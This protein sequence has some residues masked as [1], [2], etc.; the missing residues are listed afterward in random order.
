MSNCC[1]SVFN[2]GGGAIVAEKEDSILPVVIGSYIKPAAFVVGLRGRYPWRDLIL[3]FCESC[4]SYNGIK[5]LSSN[6][7]DYVNRS[8]A[9]AGYDA[10]GSCDGGLLLCG[11]DEEDIFPSVVR[12][13]V[14]SSCSR[15]LKILEEQKVTFKNPALIITL[16]DMNVIS[17]VLS[18]VSSSI[19]E[20]CIKFCECKD[21]ISNRDRFKEHLLKLNSDFRQSMVT[22]IDTF[23]IQ[24]MID[25]G[26]TLFNAYIRLKNAE[27]GKNVKAASATE[28]AVLTKTEGI[29]WIK[30]SIHAI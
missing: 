13:G 2:K 11:Y 30:H 6:F 4:P 7:R 23:D 24:D 9:F 8:D 22:G 28:I 17:P 26:E 27:T 5:D 10:Y 12:F 15:S 14:A 18:G 16:G 3:S 25:T 20:S 29:T 1:I 21:E 19:Y